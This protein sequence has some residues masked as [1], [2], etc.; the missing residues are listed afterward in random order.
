M[1]APL[2]QPHTPNCPLPP[3][4]RFLPPSFPPG[5]PNPGHTVSILCRGSNRMVLDEADRSLHDALCVI[6][7]LVQ[8]KFLIPGGA[9]PETEVAVK[10]M[11]R[12]KTLHGVQ[13][14]C[15]R[16]FAEALEIVPYTL[17]E[18][19]GLHPLTI[20]TELRRQHALGH[21]GAG[22]N[23]RKSAIT[24]MAEEDVMQPLVTSLSAL[25]LATETVRMILKI[26]DLVPVRG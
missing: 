12:A 17:A 9:A 4:T 5:V 10:M 16:A 13:S 8:R 2:V 18:N 14:H 15:V 24:D 22:I 26:D 1:R 11:E 19:A 23:I 20:V 21:H 6:R 3:L 25:K 7:S